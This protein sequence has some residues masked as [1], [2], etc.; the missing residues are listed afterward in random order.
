MIMKTLAELKRDAKSGKLFAEMTV[1]C[2]GDEIP[3]RLR[4]VRQIVDS[5]SVGIFFLNANG[6]KSELRIP[7]ASLI[8]YTGESI[9]LYGAGLRELTSEENATFDKW[10]TMRDRK[11]E[12]ID[13]LTDGSG[14]YFREKR[15]FESSKM[16]HLLGNHTVRGMKYDH[17]T[18]KVYDNKVKGMVDNV[19]KI[20]R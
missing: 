13:A 10:E 17:N 3:E 12:E 1:F 11:R 14:E 18:K 6:K 19:Y 2:G 16:E 8:E 20:V 9:I 7:S 15:F 5:N 4:G